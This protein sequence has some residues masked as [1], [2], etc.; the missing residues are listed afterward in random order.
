MAS[1]PPSSPRHASAGP[2]PR[3]RS[4][5]IAAPP[6]GF[7]YRPDFIDAQEEARLLQHIEQLGFA[8]FRMRGVDAKREVVHFGA[9]YGFDEG[10]LTA[11]P[12][13]PAWLAAPLSRVHAATGFPPPGARLAALVTRYAPGAGIGW[14]RDA[15]PFGAVVVGLSLYTAC[16]MRLRQET[17]AGFDEY[18]LTL[19][20][21]SLYVIAHHARYRW[22]HA[23]PPVQALRYSITY[24]TV[25]ASL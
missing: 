20:P 5:R 14:H 6:P 17:A 2:R 22:Q 7:T 9:R 19:A 1:P 15:P 18:R 13:I 10:E 23:L 3:R 24:R 4:R 25:R 16:E 21:R 8:P 11:A 12:P